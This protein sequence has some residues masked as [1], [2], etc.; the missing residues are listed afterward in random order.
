MIEVLVL[1][2]SQPMARVEIK[3]VETHEDGTADYSVRF[4]VER[5]SAVGLHRRLIFG[6]PR[7][8]LNALALVRLALES[9][10]EKELELERGFDPDEAPVSS[11]V[12]GGFRGALREIQ[13]GFSR[14][15]RH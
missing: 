10:N 12:V 15:H 7:K 5:G 2:N 6:F 14:L 1:K 11:D 13:G 4:G 3:N 8:R 9:L